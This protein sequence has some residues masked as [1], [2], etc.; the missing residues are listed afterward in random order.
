MMVKGS[1]KKLLAVFLVMTCM[2]T[3][4]AMA[5]INIFYRSSIQANQE[6]IN[7]LMIN[8]Q[9]EVI[10]STLKSVRTALVTLAQKQELTQ[11]GEQGYGYQ[12][13]EL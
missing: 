12:V 3:G 7:A 11:Y 9:R 6:Q 4:S 5:V 13:K 2:M 10:E 8:E 1:L